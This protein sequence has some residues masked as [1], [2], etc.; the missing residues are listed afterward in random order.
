MDAIDTYYLIDYENVGELGL[1]GCGNLKKSDHIVIFFTP[2]AKNIDMTSIFDHG[3]AELEMINVPAGKQSAD[4]HIGSYLGY[5]AGKNG[6]TCNVV[7]VSNDTDYDKVINFW[8][9]RTDISASR[10]QQIK[11]ADTPKP[12]TNRKKPAE[13]EKAAANAKGN[14]KTKLMQEVTRAVKKAG[15]QPAEP[16]KAAANPKGN[17]NT[18]LRQEVTQAMKKAGYH[19]SVAVAV[20]QIADL[21]VIHLVDLRG[22]ISLSN[23]L[24]GLAH[25]ADGLDY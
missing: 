15:Y 25:C 2:N 19:N 1:S 21:V 4:M 18:K 3:E 10:S 23:P 13:P 7:I 5:L 17:Q 20:A 8:K 16:E 24:G 22:E 6:G 12:Q 11:K 14:Q 9:E